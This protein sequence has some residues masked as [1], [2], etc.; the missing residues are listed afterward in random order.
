[1]ND[2]FDIQRFGLYARQQFRENGKM[3]LYGLLAL[4]AA[5]GWAFDH[6]YYSMLNNYSAYLEKSVLASENYNLYNSHDSFF[7]IAAVLVLIMAAESLKYF[8]VKP[9]AIHHLTLPVSTAERFGYALLLA[10]PITIAVSS[11]VWYVGDAFT[12]SMLSKQIPGLHRT[13]LTFGGQPHIILSVLFLSGCGAFLLGA[14]TL[15]KFNF[16]KTLGVLLVLDLAIYFVQR[17]YFNA[18]FEGFDI[19]FAPIPWL[20]PFVSITPEID[21][22]EN[23]R[24]HSVNAWVS[25]WWWA[26]TLPVLLLATTYFKMKEKQV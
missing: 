19:S 23:I 7:G 18:I 26:Y 8:A 17:V 6:E 15:S 9:R 25:T 5:H 22:H 10:L 3:Y 20:A 13:Q 14:V 12:F 24:L 1:M 21:P 4:I 11:L 2:T 16:F